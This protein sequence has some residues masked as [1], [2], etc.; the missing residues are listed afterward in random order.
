VKTGGSERREDAVEI[1]VTESK[2]AIVAID[3]SE[4][5]GADKVSRF[6]LKLASIAPGDFYLIGNKASIHWDLQTMW[7]LK[8]MATPSRD[9]NP[10]YSLYAIA[11]KRI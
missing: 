6:P 1:T 11:R 9:S 4:P 5:E 3:V 8:S 10:I 2:M 7:L